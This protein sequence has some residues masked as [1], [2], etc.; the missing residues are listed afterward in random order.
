MNQSIRQE[1]PIVGAANVNKDGVSGAALPSIFLANVRSLAIKIDELRLRLT[2]WMF[3]DCN[4]MVFAETWLNST[5]PN[6]AIELEGRNIFR[7]DRTAVDSGKS[8]D[9]GVCLYVNR[10]WCSD[11]VI[12]KSHCS[13]DIEY[14][15]IK[16]R[17]FY[18]PREFTTAIIAAMYVPPDA[19]AILA[20]PVRTIFCC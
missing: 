15:F 12:T 4:I 19:N 6:S 20:M 14:I 16:C 9:G 5:I 7:A 11:A 1:V 13:A 3:I 17:P 8:K 2:Q 10:S 18:L